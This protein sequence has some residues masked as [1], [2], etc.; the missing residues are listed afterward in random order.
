MEK[1]CTHCN[2]FGFILI[3]PIN[4]LYDYCPH[5]YIKETKNDGTCKECQGLGYVTATVLKNATTNIS[6]SMCPKCKDI[7]KYGEYIKSLCTDELP[8]TSTTNNVIFSNIRKAIFSCKPLSNS[9]EIT[10]DNVVNIDFN[11]L[12]RHAS[13]QELLNNNYPDNVI[14]IDFNK[15]TKT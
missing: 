4:N 7:K 11:K 10:V 13:E 14:K 6:A 8:T 5:C 9:D 15:P 2:G 3:D 1:I 12:S